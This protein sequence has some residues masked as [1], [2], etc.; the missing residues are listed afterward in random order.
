M[1]F[2]LWWLK[3]WMCMMSRHRLRWCPTC[4]HLLEV[5]ARLRVI[6]F[7]YAVEHDPV[8]RAAFDEI[9]R[10]EAEKNARKAEEADKELPDR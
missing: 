9:K 5:E 6:V 3:N 8:V 7:G 2:K 1:R 10:K 4:K